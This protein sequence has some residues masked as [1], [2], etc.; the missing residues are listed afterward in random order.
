VRLYH[1]TNTASPISQMSILELEVTIKHSICFVCFNF[2][3]DWTLLVVV[4]HFG[5]SILLPSLLLF[6]D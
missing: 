4:F 5:F 6:L 3:Y 2:C 1:S